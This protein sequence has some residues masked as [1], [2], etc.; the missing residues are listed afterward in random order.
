MIMAV[1]SRQLS[2]LL[3]HVAFLRRRRRVPVSLLCCSLR[4][5]AIREALLRFPR[6]RLIWS[7]HPTVATQRGF[8]ERN[9]LGKWRATVQTVA[10]L[11]HSFLHG[12]EYLNR[13]YGDIL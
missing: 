9:V 13:K 7:N 1:R 3:H 10:R 12:E 5:P 6:R 11:A 2:V 8:W 4:N